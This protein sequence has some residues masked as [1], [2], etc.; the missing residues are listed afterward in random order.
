MTG[1]KW[2][3]R[4]LWI[5]LAFLVFIVAF[6]QAM[7]WWWGRDKTELTH[8]DDTYRFEAKRD[9]VSGIWDL[10][11]PN[12]NSLWFAFGYLQSFDREFQSEM[13]RMAARGEASRLFGESM[14]KNDRLMRFSRRAAE[15]E[16]SRSPDFVR[17]AAEA[18]VAGRVAALRNPDH[19]EPIEYQ[20]MGIT[21]ASLPPWEPSDIV[22]IARF[23]AWQLSFDVSLEQLYIKLTQKLGTEKARLLL[24]AEPVSS[25]AL[26]SQPRLYEGVR[27]ADVLLRN[28]TSPG[29]P[30]PEA[31][32]PSV[33]SA[34]RMESDELRDS[35]LPAFPSAADFGKT[36]AYDGATQLALRGASNLW[37]VAD[38]RVGRALTLCNDTH[39][40]FTWPASLYPIRWTLEASTRGTGFM[41]PGVPAMVVGSFESLEASK[42]GAALSWGITL[43]SYGDTQDLVLVDPSLEPRFSKREESYPIRNLQTGK[44][45]VRRIEEIWTPY[46]PRVD[47]IFAE[48]SEGLTRPLSLDWLG[49]GKTPSPLEFFVR[50]NLHGADGIVADLH[51]RLSY[52]SF[53]FTW[54]EKASDGLPKVGHLATGW[55]RSRENRERDGL[56]PLRSEDLAS[57]RRDV[58][59]KDREY[60]LRDY[61]AR[62]PFF[63]ATA[64]QRIWEGAAGLGMAH[65]W[66]PDD[67]ARAIVA[68]FEQNVREPSYSQNDSRSPNLTAFLKIERR[69]NSADRLCSD[70]PMRSSQCLDLLS[71]LD[72]WDGQ[73]LVESWQPTLAALWHSYVKQEIFMSLVPEKLRPELKASVKDW[74]RRAFSS[75]VLARLLTEPE[76]QARWEKISGQR[77][78]ALSLEAFRKALRTIVE[79]RGPDDRLWSWGNFHR[80]D[81]LHPLVQAP[82]PW[83]SVFHDSL[84]GPRPQVPGALDS[85]SRFE[86]SWD[87]DKPL[88]F[89]ALHGAS[90]RMCTEFAADGGLKMR[91][92]APTGASGNPFSTF[93]KTWS[94]DTFFRGLLSDVPRP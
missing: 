41:L 48:E 88:D 60:F 59:P 20:I 47:K 69:R 18:F 56:E 17:A 94:F 15:D 81:W 27:R 67:R 61:D 53:N 49:F 87:V 10:R 43:A 65:S 33:S 8:A 13:I 35:L 21:R 22:A 46:G 93:A 82:E 86:Y 19:R 52:P 92:S 91:W 36:I 68:S 90:L 54:I 9:K 50:R 2:M 58:Q 66:E 30:R 25:Q 77:L 37:V 5:L 71:K 78:E 72:A 57:R 73:N 34:Q 32:Y 62:L 3:R 85:P 75:G 80:I 63:L 79:E 26:Y 39:L 84:L 64:N 29:L 42:A 44:I 11:A 14:L 89:P 83:G 51:E 28:K 45:E 76:T 38:P 4:L 40:R 74:H 1:V 7:G 6:S 70:T 23:H 24:P 16:F 12:Q 31:F 55:M